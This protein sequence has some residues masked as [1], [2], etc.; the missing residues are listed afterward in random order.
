MIEGLP[1]KDSN[2]LR[3]LEPLLTSAFESKHRSIVNTTI[4][5]WNST[6]GGQAT[7]EYP[8]RILVAIRRIQTIADLQL[9]SFPNDPEDEVCVT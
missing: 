6:F 4:T 3:D 1:Q 9:P 5:L 7:L 2:I 8:P